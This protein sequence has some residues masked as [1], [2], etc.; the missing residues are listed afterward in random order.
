MKATNIPKTKLN[1]N[2]A[3]NCPLFSLGAISEMY[4]GAATE[5]APIPIPPIILE[6]ISVILSG[7]KAE[8][9]AD[10]KNKMPIQKSV[11]FRPIASVGIPPNK[12]PKMVPNMAEPTV[13][14][15]SP[16]LK[17]HNF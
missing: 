11:F 10:T 9:M 15:N 4:T 12:A 3:V 13:I 7:A 17:F 8:P 5:E 1:W 6:I 2:K 16:A 14:P